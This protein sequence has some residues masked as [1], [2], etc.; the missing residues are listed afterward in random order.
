[1]SF[2]SIAKAA[3]EFYLYGSNRK[4]TAT[5]NSSASSGA[6]TGNT[7][8]SPITT[9]AIAAFAS[10]IAAGLTSRESASLSK[11]PHDF[12]VGEIIAPRVWWVMGIG[13]EKPRLRSMVVPLCW[14][15]QRGVTGNVDD[16]VGVHAWKTEALA[17][18]YAMDMSRSV[19]M[20]D[21][22]AFGTVRLWGEVV[23]CEL[24]YRAQYARVNKVN[25]I[26]GPPF[27]GKFQTLKSYGALRVE[28]N[29]IYGGTDA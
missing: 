6:N 8:A 3:W 4:T 28:L 25:V 16:G 18:E 2:I 14:H 21:A 19:P 12:E 26:L 13:Q 17:L 22:L 15:P 27:Q 20:G 24:G 23:E 5:Y 9:G 29:R 10:A 1:M 11:L 7:G